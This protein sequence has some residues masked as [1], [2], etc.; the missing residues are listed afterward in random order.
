MGENTDD[1]GPAL[2]GIPTNADTI[3]GNRQTS[4]FFNIGFIRLLQFL[5][6]NYLFWLIIHAENDTRDINSA[7]LGKMLALKGM[8]FKAKHR[9]VR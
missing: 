9:N 2:L 5:A 6:I 4:V 8:G 1:I 3:I 7:E